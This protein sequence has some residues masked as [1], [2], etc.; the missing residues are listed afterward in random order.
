M[1]VGKGYPSGNVKGVFSSKP[2]EVAAR[3]VDSNFG[4]GKNADQIKANKLLKRTHMREESL[5]G[6]GIM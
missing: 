6:K 4:P 1:P 2:K 3:R 5:R